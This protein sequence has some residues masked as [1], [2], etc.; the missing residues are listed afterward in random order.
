MLGIINISFGG[1]DGESLVMGLVDFVILIGLVC[2]FVS[3]EFFYVLIVL[4]W[5]VELVYVGICF[6][7]GWFIIE[8]EIDFVVLMVI[9]VVIWLRWVRLVVNE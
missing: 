5:S 9:D 2:I 6:F 3:L 1:V 8:V 4:G 7:V